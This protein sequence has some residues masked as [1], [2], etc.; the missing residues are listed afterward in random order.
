MT[1]VAA[2]EYDLLTVARAVVG[3]GSPETVEPL[4]RRSREM[5]PKVGPTAMA[6]LRRTLSRGV[7]LS[8]AS[9]WK[10]VRVDAGERVTSSVSTLSGE[11]IHAVRSQT[12]L[13]SAVP[14]R[15]ASRVDPMTALH[16]E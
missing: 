10:A 5:P 15:Q 3:Q 7:V 1:R 9:H 2:S 8:L 12:I 16:Y 6:L 13:A 14:A 11:L 4:L